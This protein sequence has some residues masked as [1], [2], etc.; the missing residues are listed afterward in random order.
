MKSVL[1]A[2]TPLQCAR[3][4]SGEQSIA[5]FKSAPKESPFKVY[6]LCKESTDLLRQVPVYC[7]GNHVEYTCHIENDSFNTNKVLNGKVI[8]E[9]VCDKVYRECS[10]F[11]GVYKTSFSSI[12]LDGTCLS[13]DELN[14]YGKN[15]VLRG[16]R[17]CLVKFYAEPRV[18]GDFK[19]WKKYDWWDYGFRKNKPDWDLV[20]L[21]RVPSPWCYVEELNG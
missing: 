2:F 16:W 15:S 3:I 10:N 21:S 17:V 20:G 11:D 8:G 12:F 9:F 13:V 19:H 5:V 14:A 4:A 18:L 1:A 7:N 6:M